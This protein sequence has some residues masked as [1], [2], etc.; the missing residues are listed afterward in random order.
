MPIEDN[1]HERD[2]L[3]SRNIRQPHDSGVRFSRVEHQLPEVLVHGDED[4]LLRVGPYQESPISRIG[5][6]LL[7]F[8]D[9][10]LLLAKPIRQPPAGAPVDQESHLAAT[11]TASRESFAMT[12]WA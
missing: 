7:G 8:E 11:W 2:A 10:V 5:S 4:P 9:V 1:V 12:A 3:L 6:S